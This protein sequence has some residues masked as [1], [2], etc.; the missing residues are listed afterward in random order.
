MAKRSP[1]A[2]AAQKRAQRK[3][4]SRRKQTQRRI[5][6]HAPKPIQVARAPHT[7]LVRQYSYAGY[8]LPG[9]EP[10]AP[11]QIERLA[12]T[13]VGEMRDEFE[14]WASIHSHKHASAYWPHM[15]DAQVAHAWRVFVFNKD[16]GYGVGIDVGS[17]IREYMAD[18]DLDED[19]T[20]S[21]EGNYL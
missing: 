2:R 21:D 19:I 5:T 20:D 6:G 9:P 3:T 12:T 13:T 14:H 17:E 16:Q 7:P 15:S 18:W 8:E 11:D 1:K 10:L 4:T